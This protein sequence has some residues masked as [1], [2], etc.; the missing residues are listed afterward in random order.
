[1]RTN[2]NTV[3]ITGGSNG[4]GLA[5]AE[6]FARTGNQVVVTGRRSQLL[7]NARE[8]V[9][10]LHTI[11][12]LTAPGLPELLRPGRERQFLKSVCFPSPVCSQGRGQRRRR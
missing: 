3:L 12:F 11:G 8:Q 2:G 9:P 6:R 7:D 4:I 10:G 1:M 5:L